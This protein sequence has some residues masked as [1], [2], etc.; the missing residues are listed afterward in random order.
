M[1]KPIDWLL[2]DDA[3]P[4]AY[5]ARRDLLGESSASRRM[6]T[7]RRRCNEYAP[8]ARMLAGV[9]RAIKAGGYAKYRGGYWTLIFLSDLH[10]DPGD[11]RLRKLADWVLAQ[12]LDNGGF[13]AGSAPFEIVCLTA[14][15]LRGLVHAGYGDHD[16]IR[17]GYERLHERIT[18]HGGVPCKIL[19]WTLQTSCKMTIPQTL[20]CMAVAPPSIPRRTVT[21]VRAILVEEA[22]GVRVF[23]YA[24]PDLAAYREAVR[25]RPKGKKQVEVRDQWLASHRL[26]SADL[27]EKSGWKRFGFPRSYNPD[28]L[29]AMLAL[30]ENGVP[31]RRVLDESL[32]WIES[33]R[34]EDGRWRLDDSLNGK[35]LAT[36]ERKG[37]PSKWITLRA[38]TVLQHFGR[39]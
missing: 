7:L 11:R 2:E 21:D 19:E 5:L 28:L 8:T 34:L 33:K 9:D 37:Q 22:I 16:A 4:V 3:P 35:T 23:R 36:I 1:P 30:A 29:E 13:P 10:A 27:V 24:R 12:Q 39:A 14:N 38:L 25:S 18:G 6:K 20:R 26:R 17:A 15:V 31:H 32:D